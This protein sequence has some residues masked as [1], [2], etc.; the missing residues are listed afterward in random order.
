[1]PST[2][3]ERELPFGFSPWPA[4]RS[5]VWLRQGSLHS[6]NLFA[7][8]CLQIP[9]PWAIWNTNALGHFVFFFDLF[10][11]IL[12]RV[13]LLR[14]PHQRVFFWLSSYSRISSPVC[15]D[16]WWWWELWFQVMFKR[17]FWIMVQGSVQKISS[18]F[19]GFSFRFGLT[20]W[21]VVIWF[22]LISH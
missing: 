18:F 11:A 3:L 7:W 10:W 6:F 22:I 15:L 16:F 4:V 5:L 2:I 17:G 12:L 14:F 21:G 9:E 20:P 19:L 8:R 13:E 1:M